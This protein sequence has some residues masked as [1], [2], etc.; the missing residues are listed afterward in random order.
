MNALHCPELARLGCEL[1]DAYRCLDDEI[2]LSPLAVGTLDNP[3][4]RIHQA[5]TEHRLK[6]RI[7]IQA[8]HQMDLQ[9]R[10]ISQLLQE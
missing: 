3:I 1:I 4:A 7:C 8:D 9:T 6:C 2:I 10:E 5:I